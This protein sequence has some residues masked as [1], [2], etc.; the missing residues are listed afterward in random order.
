M[1]STI[2]K[3]IISYK[4]VTAPV[5][6]VTVMPPLELMHEQLKR[7]DILV[8]ATYKIKPPGAEHALYVTCNDMVLNAGTVNESLFPY[9]I[10]INSKN[11]EHFQWILAL[12]RLISA[13]FR[14]GSNPTFLIHELKEIFDPKGG[15]L[16][17]GVYMPSLVAEIGAIIE[18]HLIKIGIII[19][20]EATDN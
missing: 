7:P 17:R 10:F 6:P 12:T 2:N 1:A 4:V 5:T 9:E 16:K 3:K 20:T 14:M 18:K 19:D 15:Y 13:I 11:M 8:G